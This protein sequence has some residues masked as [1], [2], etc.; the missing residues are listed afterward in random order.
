MPCTGAS[1][2][3]IFY[4]GKN[5]IILKEEWVMKKMKI[6]IMLVL[7]V[8]ALVS[9]ASAAL[10]SSVTASISHPGSSSY[11]DVDITSGGNTYLPTMN[12]YLGWCADSHKIG[13]G[14]GTTFTP[15]DMRYE[16]PPIHTADWNRINWILNHKNGAMPGSV[17]QAIWYFDNGRIGSSWAPFDET[18]VQA[19]IEDANDNGGGYVPV[20]EGLKYAVILYNREVL[21]PVFIEATIP[22][23]PEMPEFPTLALPVAMLVGLVGVVYT[24]RSREE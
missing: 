13:L 21:Q 7:A 1:Q 20:S 22:K 6:G 19:L 2:L 16:N 11:F 23:P 3:F 15:Y 8:I 18:E 10:P 17:Q 9:V 5:S 24:I 4:G 12:D 14:P